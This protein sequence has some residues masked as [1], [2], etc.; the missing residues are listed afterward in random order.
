M[1]D[2]GYVIPPVGHKPDIILNQRESTCT[3][4]GYSGDVYCSVCNILIERGYETKPI[5]HTDSDKDG[6]CDKCGAKINNSS[7][8]SNT[9]SNNNCFGRF[10]DW[11]IELIKN[12]LY[13]VKSITTGR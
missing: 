3:S 1:I 2:K 8:D 7:T 5:G 10:L 9:D 4:N 6:I 11:I 12:I 13:L